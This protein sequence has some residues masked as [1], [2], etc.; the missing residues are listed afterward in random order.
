MS[1]DDAAPD[2]PEKEFKKLEGDWIPVGIKQ[3]GKIRGPD[4]PVS[5]HIKAATARI[6]PPMANAAA[7]STGVKDRKARS[8]GSE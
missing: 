1:A 4:F 2:A 8:F 5:L 7:A 3:G 6:E